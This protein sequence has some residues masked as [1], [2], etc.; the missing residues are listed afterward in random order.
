MNRLGLLIS[1]I[2]ILCI[3]CKSEYDQLVRSE[4]SSGVV[5][6]ELILGLKMGQSQKEFFGICWKLNEQQLVSH[7]PNN[8]NVRYVMKKEEID[9]DSNTV[10]MLFY[11]IFDEERVMRG[12]KKKISYLR[13][14][15]WAEDYHA[16]AL[17]PKLQ[18]YYIRKFPGNP[19]IKVDLGLEKISTYVKVDGNRQI[20]MYPID[21][22]DIV[23]KIE[24][25]RY[26]M[27]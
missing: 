17:I 20:L 1:I 12:L 9:A 8:E 26:K 11:G 10:E 21:S 15:P 5:Y 2:G 16:S 7:G 4:L 18:D 13:W 27:D 24:D 6:E 23:V 22:K 3:S 19:F 14:A 25:L